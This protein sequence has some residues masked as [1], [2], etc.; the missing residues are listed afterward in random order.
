MPD[1]TIANAGSLKQITFM[2]MPGK[3]G[4]YTLE[5]EVTDFEN[6]WCQYCG[7]AVKFAD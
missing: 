4:T 1:A 3:G 2:A 7:N 6:G 5:A